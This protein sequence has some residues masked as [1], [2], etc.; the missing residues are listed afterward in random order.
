MPHIV[1]TY[2][3]TTRQT[4]RC[5]GRFRGLTE[6]LPANAPR[7]F[8]PR[9]RSAARSSAYPVFWHEIDENAC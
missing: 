3:V 5:L 1:Q 9:H 4:K 7:R 6:R 8:Q 2:A